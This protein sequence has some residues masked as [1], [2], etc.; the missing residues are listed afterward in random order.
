MIYFCIS[1]NM[2]SDGDIL[3]LVIWHFQGN[4]PLDYEKNP[5]KTIIT[6]YVMKT[7]L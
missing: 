2:N 6:M 5:D 7:W 4:Y 3:Y 1:M